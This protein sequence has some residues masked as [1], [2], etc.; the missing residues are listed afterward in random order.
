MLAL[1]GWWLGAYEEYGRHNYNLRVSCEPDKNNLPPIDGFRGSSHP[2]PP[3]FA[4]VDD[5]MRGRESTSKPLAD[6]QV[7]QSTGQFPDSLLL[8]IGTKSDHYL[9]FSLS[10]SVS[11]LVET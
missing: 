10:K 2:N 11:A 7:L 8:F 6:N 1:D 4:S 5:K 9:A 3:F